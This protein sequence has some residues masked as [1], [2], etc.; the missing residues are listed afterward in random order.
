MDAI[1]NI[2][3][4][5]LTEAFKLIIWFLKIFGSRDSCTYHIE[6]VKALETERLK[7]LFE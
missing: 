5:M 4:G 7:M 1:L 6:I 2:Q 3:M